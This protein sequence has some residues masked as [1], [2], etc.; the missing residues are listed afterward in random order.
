MDISV[1]FVAAVA[2]EAGGF[3]RRSQAGHKTWSEPARDGA[4]NGDI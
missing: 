3:E 4:I 1:R 2:K